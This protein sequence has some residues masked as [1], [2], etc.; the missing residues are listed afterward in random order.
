MPR[1]SGNSVRVAYYTDV[2]EREWFLL[3]TFGSQEWLWDTPDVLR[4]DPESR[5]LAGAEFELPGK[6]ASTEDSARVPV[7]PA[8]RGQTPRGRG[9]GPSGLEVGRD[10]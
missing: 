3:A 4:F 7:L 2:K 10:R 9:T 6:F 5:E 8:A 1:F